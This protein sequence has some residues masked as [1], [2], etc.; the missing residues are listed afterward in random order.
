MKWTN[1]PDSLLTPVMPMN[2]CKHKK[3]PRKGR[4]GRDG[5]PSSSPRCLSLRHPGS[6]VQWPLW[7]PEERGKLAI[8]SKE[9]LS[10]SQKPGVPIT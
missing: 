3:Q 8:H 10:R 2:V 1:R 9:L 4:C 6:W 5:L 7:S